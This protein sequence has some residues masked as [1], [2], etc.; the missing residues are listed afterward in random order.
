MLCSLIQSFSHASFASV[1]L[2]F[3]EYPEPKSCTICCA[4]VSQDWPLWW[5]SQAK[6]GRCWIRVRGPHPRRRT[7]VAPLNMARRVRGL[8]G[9]P[10]KGDARKDTGALKAGSTMSAGQQ[11]EGEGGMALATDPLGVRRACASRLPSP[12]TFLGVVAG[13]PAHLVGQPV[14]LIHGVGVV[15]AVVHEPCV[16]MEGR[17]RLNSRVGLRAQRDVPA[18]WP[19]RRPHV[20]ML[21]TCVSSPAGAGGSMAGKEQQL[22]SRGPGAG[23]Y[24]GSRTVLGE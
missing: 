7:P 12:R 24:H 6:E 22:G 14:G 11:R 16:G 2:M 4:A 19:T 13:I 15:V 18:Q 3:L 10:R 21:C 20:C 1:C 23:Q 9:A 17:H 5:T 8:V